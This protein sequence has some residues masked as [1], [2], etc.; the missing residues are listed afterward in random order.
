MDV[1]IVELTKWGPVGVVLALMLVF[2]R[3]PI[4]SMFFGSADEKAAESLLH[5]IHKSFESNLVEFRQANT[6]LT[7][8]N[9]RLTDIHLVLKSIREDQHD[10]LQIQRDLRLEVAKQSSFLSGRP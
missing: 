8:T 10:L 4:A 3:K 7:V 5:A 1:L 6:Q 2:W 9:S